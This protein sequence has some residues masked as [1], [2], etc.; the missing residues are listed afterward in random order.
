[1]SSKNI[2]IVS[3]D[4]VTATVVT[5]D[6]AKNLSIP[7]PEKT[8]VSVKEQKGITAVVADTNTASVS[9]SQAPKSSVLIKQS[10]AV[11][12]VVIGAKTLGSLSGDKHFTHVQ[13]SPSDRWDVTHNLAK[14]PSVTIVDSAGTAVIGHVQYNSIN[15][16]TIMFSGAFSGRAYFN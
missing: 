14:N 3:G 2:K 11:P 6:A 8:S 4:S 1:M 5:G 15:E 16:V 13:S 10:T 7:A 9:V 12:N